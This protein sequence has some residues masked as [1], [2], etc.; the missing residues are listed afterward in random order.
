MA[1]VVTFFDDQK[2]DCF[3]KK[4]PRPIPCTIA[5]VSRALVTVCVVWMEV[6]GDVPDA[7]EDGLPGIV[8]G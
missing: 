1:Q 2:N 4:N 8:S 5:P 7:L 3:N 6:P